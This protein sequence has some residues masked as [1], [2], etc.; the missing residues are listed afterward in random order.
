MKEF[1]KR[2]SFVSI[3]D[4]HME[5]YGK[6]YSC[7]TSGLNVFL[8]RTNVIWYVVSHVDVPWINIF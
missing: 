7:F 2:V 4:F 6:E 8:A 5:R 3:D 1:L